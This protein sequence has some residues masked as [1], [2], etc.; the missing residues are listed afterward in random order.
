MNNMCIIA[1]TLRSAYWYVGIIP[2]LMPA[3]Y[4]MQYYLRAFSTYACTYFES[5]LCE[6]EE[7]FSLI[8]ACSISLYRTIDDRRF[9]VRMRR[10]VRLIFLARACIRSHLSIVRSRAIVNCESCIGI[11]M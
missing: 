9:R 11:G 5:R 1:M 4:S 8:R 2:S 3:R 10:Y 7:L 6:S